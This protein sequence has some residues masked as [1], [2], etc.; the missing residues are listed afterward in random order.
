M[1]PTP[2]ILLPWPKP[3]HA[4]ASRRR[5]RARAEDF[6]PLADFA[7]TLP[8]LVVGCTGTVEAAH[9]QSRGAGG[10]A[11]RD[12]AGVKIG[13]IAPLCHA[14]H[15]EQHQIGRV[16]FDRRHLFAVRLPLGEAIEVETMADG[17]AVVGERMPKDLAT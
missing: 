6:G 1:S 12:E 15:A 14:H 2:S 5:R 10:H 9:V 3:A 17:A 4:S 11:W 13:N 8:C 7:R 16:T